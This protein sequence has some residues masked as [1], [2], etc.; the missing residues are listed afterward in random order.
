MR[1]GS[2]A[3]AVAAQPQYQQ[4]PAANYQPPA[5]QGGVTATPLR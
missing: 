2:A 5:Y 4:Q 3:S 1:Y